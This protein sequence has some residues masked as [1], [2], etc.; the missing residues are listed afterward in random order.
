M[1]K[2]EVQ[3]ALVTLYLRLSGYFTSGFIVHSPTYG[4]N[5]TEL[6]VLATSQFR[7]LKN[8]RWCSRA[9]SVGF[10]G[11]DFIIGEVRSLGQQLQSMRDCA[12]LLARYLMC[13]AGRLQGNGFDSGHGGHSRATGPC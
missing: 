4:Q 9:R 5:R 1:I 7:A 6:D 13:L 12:C 8:R 11:I 3:G 10:I 2:S